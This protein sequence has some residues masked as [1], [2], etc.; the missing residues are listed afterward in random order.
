MAVDLRSVPLAAGTRITVLIPNFSAWRR[1][2]QWCS[3]SLLVSSIV[4]RPNYFLSLLQT[5][6]FLAWFWWWVLNLN[7]WSEDWFIKISV[8]VSWF[9]SLSECWAGRAGRQH[10]SDQSGPQQAGHCPGHVW[11]NTQR[12]P[13]SASAV[14]RQTKNNSFWTSSLHMIF[15]FD[16]PL[17]FYLQTVVQLSSQS[18]LSAECHSQLLDLEFHCNSSPAICQLVRGPTCFQCLVTECWLES[19]H[20]RWKYVL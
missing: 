2:S 1:C 12:K 10:W 19:L 8:A 20:Y 3:V 14:R 17:E 13:L 11:E 16:C 18:Q 4:K 7:G 9:L 6:Q 15:H 5:E